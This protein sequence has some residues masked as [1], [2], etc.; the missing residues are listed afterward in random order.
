[1]IDSGPVGVG[2]R[3]VEVR[4]MFGREVRSPFSITLHD[5]PGR[6]DFHTTG[7]PIRPDGIMRC[8]NED[9]ACRVSYEM[10]LR[11]PLAPL[12]IRGLSNGM[13]GNLANLKRVLEA[14]S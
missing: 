3:A 13:E 8:T 7:G 4:R 6:Q 10:T 12:M 9:G 5:P 1:M 2:T 14:Q 11:G